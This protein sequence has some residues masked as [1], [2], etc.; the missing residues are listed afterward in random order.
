MPSP[1]VT[2]RTPASLAAF[3]AAGSCL[4][5]ALDGWSTAE[6]WPADGLRAAVPETYQAGLARRAMEA[7][8]QAAGVNP[9][10]VKVLLRNDASPAS[11]VGGRETSIAAGLVAGNEF[12]GRSMGPTDLLTLGGELGGRVEGLAASLSGGLQMATAWEKQAATAP[13]ALPLGLTLVLFLMEEIP[14]EEAISSRSDRGQSSLDAWRVTML[15]NAM[16]SLRLEDLESEDAMQPSSFYPNCAPKRLI[17]AGA[18]IGGALAALPA[19][20]GFVLAA[21][22]RGKEMTIAYE[23]AEAA[24]QARLPGAIKIAKPT[25]LGAHV[26]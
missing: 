2:V 1:L 15:A 7:L 19:D 21:L 4:G 26:I 12:A 23:M 14:P 24:R 9:P 20:D 5:L 11:T 22:T 13:V 17:C 6:V 8:W 18:M 25:N 10:S 3:G 16:A